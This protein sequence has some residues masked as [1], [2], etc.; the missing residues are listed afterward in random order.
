[1]GIEIPQTKIQ[2]HVG[3]QFEGGGTGLGHP[4]LQCEGLTHAACEIN[5][6]LRIVMT[7]QL[8]TAN[9]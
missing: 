1:M 7:N 8:T 2:G 3:Q 5:C 9:D 4:L 6:C